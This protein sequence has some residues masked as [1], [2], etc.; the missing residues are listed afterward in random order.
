MRELPRIRVIILSVET[1]IRAMIADTY[2]VLT[3]S[4][5][6]LQSCDMY[7][8]IQSSQHHS[9]VSAAMASIYRYRN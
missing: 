8:L 6:Q 5:P 3:T 2:S 4:Q 9:G 7:E 1:L